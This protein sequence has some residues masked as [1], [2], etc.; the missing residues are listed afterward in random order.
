MKTVVICVI[1]LFIAM[2]ASFAHALESFT[3]YDNFNAKFINED[4]W[5][6]WEDIDTGVNILD[7]VRQIS[8]GRLHML[9]RF[10]GN[11]SSNTG[12]SRGFYDLMVT[13]PDTITAMEATVQVAR[14][15]ADS[16]PTNSTPTTAA[17]VLGG[18]FFNTGTPTGGSELNDVLAYIRIELVSNSTN[19]PGILEVTGYVSQC[20][21]STC[22]S[23]TALQSE[24]LGTIKVG[25]NTNLS[26]QWDQPNHQFIFKFGSLAPVFVAY[27]VSDTSLPGLDFKTLRLRNYIA[28]CTAE[29]RLVSFV[30]A[31][32][33]NV[34]VN[35]S[36]VP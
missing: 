23:S 32:F 13:D 26:I 20:N 27:G 6:G 16:C 30:E 15:E 9:S 1:V 10:Y 25:V 17:V 24:T 31:Y 35:Q 2:F 3:L 19:K 34:F 28:N 12:Q 5:F 21:D 8:S 22:S 14:I 33:D 7:E 4:L 29:P 18:A 36:A 11:M